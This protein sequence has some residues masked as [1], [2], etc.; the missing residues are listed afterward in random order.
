[1]QQD[2]SYF[3]RRAAQEQAAA[4]GAAD[5]KVREAHEQMAA[6]YRALIRSA[7]TGETAAEATAD[8]AS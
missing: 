6:H 2:V 3:V 4:R 7:E 5:A 8:A 1:M